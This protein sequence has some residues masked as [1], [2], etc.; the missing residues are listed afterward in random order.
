MC[1][2]SLR[3]PQSP[4]A[5]SWSQNRPGA[6]SSRRAA[7]EGGFLAL[8]II[9]VL[10]FVIVLAAI[11]STRGTPASLHPA[12]ITP[13]PLAPQPRSVTP[14]PLTP[15]TTPEATFAITVSVGE[16]RGPYSAAPLR[17]AAV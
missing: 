13:P 1:P 3:F 14:P 15:E 17:A 4:T 5:P 8:F 11:R 7:F 12:S 6:S 2:T 10:I 9:L 16:G